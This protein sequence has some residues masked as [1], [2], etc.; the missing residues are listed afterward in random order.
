LVANCQVRGPL[1]RHR[2]AANQEGNC[3][4]FR[5]FDSSNFGESVMSLEVLPVRLDPSP[6]AL[7]RVETRLQNEL[8]GRVRNL[9]IVLHDRGIV[10]RGL[11]R[12]YY[13][14]Q[15]AQH[16]VMDALNLPIIANEIEV[17]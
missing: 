6:D 8:N 13:S 9:Q 14:K 17:G 5:L 1:S 16:A 11:A 7:D 15:L 2:E 4:H 10:L 3:S 12:T